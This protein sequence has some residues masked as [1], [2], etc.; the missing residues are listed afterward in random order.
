MSSLERFA[1]PVERIEDL[2]PQVGGAL[3]A[4]LLPGEAVRQIIYAPRQDRP[5][6]RGGGLAARLG[7]WFASPRTPACALVLTED[8]LLVATIPEAPEQ[9]R[10]AVAPLADVL[11]LELGTILLFSW[12]GWS[13]AGAGR[14][15]G[16]RVYFN[17]VRD[18]L[19]W[20]LMNTAR[21]TIIARSGRPRPAGELH[22]NLFEP[23]PYKFRNLI[24]LRLLFP[25]E[26][27]QALVCQ[28]AIWGRRLGVFRFQR[29]PA[30][31]VVLSP[32][33]LLVAQDDM[34]NIRA[35]YGLIARY[36][37]RT[38]LRRAALEQVKGDL[39]LTVTLGVHNTEEVMRYLF[40]PAAEPAL[41]ALVAAMLEQT[42]DADEHG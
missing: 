3:Q 13:W 20:G 30:T 10:V 40:E 27:V 7:A 39:W 1:Y 22:R 5:P 16:Q 29:S 15:L 19:F 36:S 42:D 25:D 41:Q 38:R 35:T 6:A 32:D 34:T 33:H 17:T 8:R 4:R 2:A 28:P 26:P 23:L 11:W 9:P 18:D 21:R 12:I 24:P 14:P 31:V 37:P